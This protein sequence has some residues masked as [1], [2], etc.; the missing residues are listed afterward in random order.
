ME[1]LP[2]YAP[3]IAGVIMLL[4]AVWLFGVNPSMRQSRAFAT[5]LIVRGIS[6]LLLT[7]VA[8]A[9]SLEWARAAATL[10]PLFCLATTFAV[11]YFVAVYPAARSWLPGG[12]MGPVMFLLPPIIIGVALFFDTS[13]AKPTESLKDVGPE[14]ITHWLMSTPTG[15]IGVAPTLLDLTMVLPAFALVRDYLGSAPGR[16]KNTLLLVSLG[17]FAPAACSCLMAGAFLHIRGALPRPADPSLFNYVE[18]AI[19]G[20]WFVAM[21]AL[22]IYLGIKAVREPDQQNRRAAALFAIIISISATIGVA[23]A[24]LPEPQ[25][26]VATIFIMVAFWSTLGAALVTYGVLRHSLFDIDIKFKLTVKRSTV[27]AVFVAVYFLAS[28]L[29]AQLFE[30]FSGS[31][32]VGIAAAA[33]LL[34][35][36]RR[37]ERFAAAFADRSM[38]NTKPL[39][40]L[41]REEC[42][43]FYA[44]QVELVCMD[45]MLSAKDRLVLDNL[46]AKLGLGPDAAKEIER[47]IIDSDH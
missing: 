17:F 37:I 5:L 36:E 47:N 3:S 19:F 6:L 9:W 10:Y 43:T 40:Q 24:T 25:T 1:L 13:L 15:P 8:V 31:T 7:I 45:G 32:Y 18:M 33:L 12:K 23:A 44:E 46:G 2:Y 4:L 28:E 20:V 16:R 34:L 11:I 27:A 42:R 41:D 14:A 39:A 22:L 30:D 21:T 38:P 29:T 35:V 26:S